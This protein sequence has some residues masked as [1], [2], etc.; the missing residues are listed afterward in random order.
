MVD[1]KISELSAATTPLAGTELAVLVQGGITKKIASSYFLDAANLTGSLA[2]GRMPAFT[3]DATSSAGAVALTLATVNSNTGS[4]GSATAA[5]TFTVNGKG[6]ITAAGS[7]T[8]TPAWSSV[9]SKPTTLSGYSVTA[10][11]VL[12]TLLTVDGA[13]SGIDADLLDGQQ[14]SYYLSATNLNAGT[15]P[16]ARMPA[17]TG[18]ATSSA[19]AVALT[20][21]TVNANVGSFGS[22]T[23]APT[24][25][26]N[27]KGLITA[28][29]STTITPAWSSI[30]SKPT[31]ISG[32]GLTDAASLG[33]N[34]FSGAQLVGVSS[35]TAIRTGGS[36]GYVMLGQGQSG[37]ED[38][39][40]VGVGY[41]SIGLQLGYGV[42]SSAVATSFVSS[43][44]GSLGRSIID[45]TG[46]IIFYTSAAQAV[47]VGS[48]ITLTERLKISS[49]GAVT[50]GGNTAWHAGN[51]G[52]G[53]GLDADLLDGIN[54]AA[55]M[56]D[57][58]VSQITAATNWDAIVSPGMYGVASG[59]AFTGTGNP[60][61]VYTYG[62]LVVTEAEGQGLQQ[63]YYSH[64]GD[65]LLY[66]SGWNNGG[67]QPWQQIWTS[68]SD[69]AGSGL[70][71]DLLDGQHGSYY[72]SA[73][74]INAGTLSD[75][76]LPSTMVGKTF[77]S[78]VTGTASESFRVASDTGYYS[79]YNTAN[80]TRWAYIQ[81]NGTMTIA[82]EVT[83]SN[84]N[85][86]TTGTGVFRVNSNLVWHAG[87]DGAGSTLD[88]DLLDGQQGAYY[89]PIASP[90]FTGTVTMPAFSVTS[91][92]RLKSS[93]V[94]ITG[95]GAFLDATNVYSFVKDGKHQFGVMAQDAQ[96]VRPELVSTIPHD[97][98]GTVLTVNPMD[99]LFALVAEVK[100]LRK[101]MAEMEAR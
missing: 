77:S 6:L 81:H 58:G 65:K 47:T 3:G 46:D 84:T 101:R 36:N 86:V 97:E 100:D 96:T 99:Y 93:I 19:G 98:F 87:N 42:K 13:A 27:A 20:L 39:A 4:F 26:V 64:I 80:N 7:A 57:K 90:T 40:L 91:D 63:T 69:G 10:A 21:A 33:A 31:T 59:T 43:Y 22:A 61:S 51:D 94:A 70:D 60:G 68:T 8:I 15:V 1:T 44:S 48:A 11:D 28:A 50:I 35:G 95:H 62:H 30:T 73:S 92:A 66:R 56:Y 85:V 76:Y 24:F 83:N 79:W 16:A 71:A 23:A 25:T 54:S 38:I 5:P 18:D 89:A 55:F 82:N 74:N 72:Q 53:S 49:A 88:A 37:T 75:S 78:R 32:Y 2:A 9:T 17:H 14:G 34:T 52:A 67:W 12:A 29:S 41:S 45:V